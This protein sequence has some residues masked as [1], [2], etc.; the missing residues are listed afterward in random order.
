MMMIH[1]HASITPKIK[2]ALQA[3]KETMFT[4]VK[5]DGI[6]ELTVSK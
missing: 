6:S 2:A 5:R 3:S 1:R 4:L